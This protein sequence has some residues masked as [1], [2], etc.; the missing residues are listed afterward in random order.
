MIVKILDMLKKG[1]IILVLSLLLI[2]LSFNI[3]NLTKSKGTQELNIAVIKHND[4][5]VERIVLDSLEEPKR[6]MISGVYE[7]CIVAEKGRIRFEESNCP[8]KVCVNTGWLSKK[9]SVAVCLP[10]HIIIKIEGGRLDIDGG[11]Y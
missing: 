7:A 9:G 2:A 10:N 4:K 11:T 3:F 5:V 6:I 1:D 8:D